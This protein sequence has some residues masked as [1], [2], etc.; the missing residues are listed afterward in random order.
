ML[1]LWLILMTLCIQGS[2]LISLNHLKCKTPYQLMDH[3]HTGG[4]LD[5]AQFLYFDNFRSW[6]KELK[7]KECCSCPTPREI[8]YCVMI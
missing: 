1:Q 8:Q 5:S 7:R 4:R 2:L 6:K 3:T